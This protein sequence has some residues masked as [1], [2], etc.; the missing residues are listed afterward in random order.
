MSKVKFVWSNNSNQNNKKQEAKRAKR[1]DELTNF[2]LIFAVIATTISF[3]TEGQLIFYAGLIALI[4]A[5]FRLFVGKNRESRS[6]E[7]EAYLNIMRRTVGSD[8]KKKKK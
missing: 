7:N 3:F 1:S 5:L 8:F 2:L 6:K 4:Y